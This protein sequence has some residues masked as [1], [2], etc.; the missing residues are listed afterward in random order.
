MT[1]TRRIGGLM[2]VLAG[3]GIVPSLRA[4]VQGFK[5]VTAAELADPSPN[6]WLSFSRTYDDQRFSPLNQIN[7]QNV[8]RLRMAWT[9]GMPAGTVES[10]PLVRGSTMYILTST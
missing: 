6:D 8:S 7:R 9:R 4:Q 3:T 1:G 5:P 10:T 2:M